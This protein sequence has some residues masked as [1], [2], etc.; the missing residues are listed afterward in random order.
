MCET[1]VQVRAPSDQ[2]VFLDVVILSFAKDEALRQVTE[3]CLDSLVASEDPERIRLRIWVLESNAQTPAYKQPGVATLYPETPFNY[4]AYMNIGIREGQAPFVAICNNDLSFHPGWA[5]ELLRVFEQDPSVSSAS[6]AC[7]LHHPHNG[8]ALNSGVY[9]GYGVLKEISGWCLVFRRS[10]LEVIGALDER[11]FFWY[12]DNDY[13]L[14]LQSKGLRHVLVTSSVVDHLDSRTL[15]THTSARQ[16]LM[17]KRA[18]YTFEEK[19]LGRSK[20]YL[21]RK[22]LKLYLKF[23]LYYL[24][25]KKVK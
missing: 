8:F 16:W 14:T 13:A 3:H 9:P 5:S 23:P 24:G 10:I 6:P 21:M 17:T 22:K 15:R 1:M 2:A 20:G 18:K 11:F 12:A 19:W 25:L 7:S 4:H